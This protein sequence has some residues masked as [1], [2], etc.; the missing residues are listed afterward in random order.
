VFADRQ[1]DMSKSGGE[2]VPSILVEEVM[3]RHPAV[4]N[5]AV[6]GLPHPHWIEA[7]FAF[8]TLRPG[9]E[10]DANGLLA[11][12]RAHLSSF[13]VPKGI[14]ILEAIPMTASGKCRKSE[15]REQ[16]RDHFAV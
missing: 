15:L 9:A 16:F 1:K 10:A 7:V 12:A 13:Q 6:V 4:A 2:N 5:A 14:M 11:H 3:L 8:V